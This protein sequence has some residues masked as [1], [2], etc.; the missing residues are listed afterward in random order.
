MS[1][2]RAKWKVI[3]K[4]VKKHLATLEIQDDE[5]ENSLKKKREIQTVKEPIKLQK[6]YLLDSNIP[7]QHCQQFDECY[8]RIYNRKC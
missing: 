5:T 4:R 2:R 3:N 7:E 8:N 1:S 6:T